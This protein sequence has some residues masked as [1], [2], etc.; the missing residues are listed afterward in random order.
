M[1]W[2]EEREEG[3]Y[4]ILILKVKKKCLKISFKSHKSIFIGKINTIY[5]YT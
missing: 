5:S 4:I 3:S 1:V 2:R